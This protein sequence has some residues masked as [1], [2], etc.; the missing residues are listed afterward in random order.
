MV[1]LLIER[2]HSYKLDQLHTHL[3]TLDLIKLGQN[4]LVLLQLQHMSGVVVDLAVVVVQE[5]LVVLVVMQKQLLMLAVFQ[6][7]IW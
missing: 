2:S 3:L 5:D 4:H 1:K 7:C 6:P